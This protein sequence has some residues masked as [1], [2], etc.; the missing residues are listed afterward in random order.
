MESQVYDIM[1]VP[2]VLG[3][4]EVLK[5]VGL[6]KRFCPLVALILGVLIGVFYL[7]EIDIKQGILKGV[8]LGLSAVGMYSG[9]KNL[10]MH[11]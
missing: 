11:K 3:V 10:I 4:V 9:T 1:L 2:I 8:Y 7:G 5:N 6:P